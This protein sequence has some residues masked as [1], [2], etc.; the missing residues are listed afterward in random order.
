M[1]H[2]KELLA[3][4]LKE[5]N[6]EL[7]DKQQNQFMD[8]FDIYDDAYDEFFVDDF[9][10]CPYC[11]MPSDSSNPDVLCSD[12]RETFGHVFYSEL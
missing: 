10:S 11:G 2:G 4:G 1:V 7:S 3:E 9:C 12:C 8:Y 5:L 6:L